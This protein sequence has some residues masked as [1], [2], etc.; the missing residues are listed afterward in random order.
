M[1]RGVRE[2]RGRIRSGSTSWGK[3]KG[4]A[5]NSGKEDGAEREREHASILT[6]FF[7]SLFS[8]LSFRFVTNAHMAHGLDTLIVVVDLFSHSVGRGRWELD[9]GARH[10]GGISSETIYV[11]RE[12]EGR[13]PGSMG[14]GMASHR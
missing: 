6:R 2:G 8:P 11:V 9:D 10:E 13:I 3:R 1:K 12:R 7:L 14:H 5:G 4:G